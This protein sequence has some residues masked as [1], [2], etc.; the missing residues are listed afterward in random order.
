[1]TTIAVTGMEPGHFGV[2]VE[3]GDITTSCRVRLTEGFVDDLSLGGIDP[4]RIVHE[5]IA[6]LVE[7]EPATSLPSELSLDGISRDHPEYYDE[8][9]AR[10]AR[11]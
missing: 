10:L 1:M 5:S 2:Q 3:E 11:G 4:D 6:F 8:L 9:R 7:R